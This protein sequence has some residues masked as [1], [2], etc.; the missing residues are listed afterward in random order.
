MSEKVTNNDNTPPKT[1]WIFAGQ[2]SQRQGMG[3]DIYGGF[4]EIRPIF[5]SKACG[6]DLRKL[7]FEA[8]SDTLSNTRYTQAC[9]AA[10]AAAVVTLLK[11]NG[12]TPDMVAGLSLGEYSALHAAGVFDFD[13]LLTVL[14][15]RGTI[16]ADAYT[17]PARMTAIFGLDDE[18]VI[19][20][21]D[22]ARSETE[23]VVT[24]ANFNCPGQVVI[25][26][27]E[28]AVLHAE[29][30]LKA[31]GARRCIPLTTSGPFHTPLM[32][33]A[34]TLLAEK[35]DQLPFSTQQLPVVFNVTAATASD[36]Q[37]KTLLT[38]QLSAPVRFA[39]SLRTLRDVG[40]DSIIE[41]GPGRVLAGLAK[42]TIPEVTVKS[43]D[44]VEDL[45]EVLNS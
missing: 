44:N 37:V 29:E 11:N 9:M 41:I 28:K 27:S 6:F 8:P 39:Q 26:G 1:A 17:L 42:R 43:I 34:A 12:K 23:E 18:V 40:V 5:E 16:M 45:R 38:R 13:T 32:E 22:Q 36:S 10:F 35:L 7:C 2:G 15:F 4:P 24:C 14:A 3:H 19:D 20:A 21:V 25:S 31:L 30:L 33:P